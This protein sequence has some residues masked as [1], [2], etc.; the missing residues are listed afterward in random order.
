MSFE[1]CCLNVMLSEI[2]YKVNAQ[3]DKVWHCD[4]LND[5]N[6]VKDVFHRNGWWVM[7]VATV[8][9]E[10]DDDNDGCDNDG[11]K[12]NFTQNIP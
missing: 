6:N 1:V 5:L 12:Y 11:K 4:R 7:K 2:F 9:V 8:Y 10:H 3:C